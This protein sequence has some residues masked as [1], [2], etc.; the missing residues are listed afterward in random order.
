MQSYWLNSATMTN[1]QA[2][3]VQ[4]ALSLGLTTLATSS[5]SARIDSEILL[6]HVLHCTRTWL[7]THPEHTL[8]SMHWETY[9]ALIAQRAKGHP[10]AYLVQYQDF[11]SLCLRVTEDT[12][13]PRPETELLVELTLDRLNAV[14]QA[15]ILE[16]GTGSGAIA[17]ALATERP[18]WS[19]QAYDLSE[20]AL[21]IAQ[22]NAQNLHVPHIQ[23]GRSNWFESVPLQSFHAIIANPPYIAEQD[24]HLNQGDLCFEPYR[25]LASGADGLDALTTIIA[26]A[27]PYLHLGGLILLEHGFDQKKFVTD[28]FRQY[29]YTQIQTIQDLNGLDRVSL[30][31]RQRKPS[32]DREG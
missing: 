13:I 9:Q 27:M 20:A 17:L 18:K 31:Y 28:L 7:Y 3:T 19:I 11:W 24:P 12:L 29:G 1:P 32:R 10:I 16:L 23:F 26:H 4:S 2:A 5:T 8:S 25:A 6:A 30:A 14:E 22:A 15:Q 21:C